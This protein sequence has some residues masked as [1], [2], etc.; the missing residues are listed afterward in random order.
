M[1]SQNPRGVIT[2]DVPSSVTPVVEADA[3]SVVMCGP[4]PVHSL[5]SYSWSASGYA[6]VVNVA[7]LC[8]NAVDFA[9]V[10]GISNAKKG[11][12]TWVYPACEVYDAMFIENNASPLVV[13]NPYDPWKHS[14][15]LNQNLPVTNLEVA[16]TKEVILPSLTVTGTGGRTYLINQDF[17]FAYNDDTLMSATLTVFAASAMASETSV[18]CHFNTPNLSA[19]TANTIIGGVDPVTGALT[20][21]EVLEHVP[22]DTGI[23]PAQVITPSWSSTDT[24]CAA[25]IARAESIS[26]GRYR[27]VF[28]A[29]IDSTN[30]GVTNYTQLYSWKNAHNFVSDFLIAGWPLFTLGEKVYHFSSL[31]ATAQNVTAA[32]F[33]NIPY[34]VP[35]N[36]HNVAFDGMVLAN[37]TRVRNDL[38]TMDW[39]ENQGLISGVN[40]D[41]WTLLGDYLSSYPLELQPYQMWTN[42]RF[43]F[44][45]LGNTMTRTL[46]SSIDM[47][48]NLR[49]LA[50]IGET[51]QQYGNH[52]C[53]VQA[54]NTFRVVFDPA[55]NLA[56]Q[57][58]SGIYVFTIFWT[59][60][61]PIR[62]LQ[63]EVTYS[64][65]DLAIWISNVTIPTIS[66]Q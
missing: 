28:I 37:G 60:P 62:Q 10:L 61:T 54:C 43:M 17:S 11:D 32:A 25:G 33:G 63:L 58:E 53:A 44:N 50:S 51:I 8:N 29:D 49:T 56:Q 38:S 46:K 48:G 23:I 66:T 40:D 2:V 27:A 22:T 41:G 45:F 57:V 36:K 9:T 4:A 1:A 42:E 24:V 64:V 52:L 18:T 19:I 14:V 12:G 5:P 20:G 31:Y 59:P 34:A 6:S 55:K 7:V 30:S 3:A 13:I 26:N 21:L 35:S 39:I 47:P 65:E 16:I 15:A